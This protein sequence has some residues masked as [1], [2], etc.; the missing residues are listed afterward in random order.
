MKRQEESPGRSASRDPDRPRRF[1]Q[2]G[3]SVEEPESSKRDKETVLRKVLGITYEP[4]PSKKYPDRTNILV[5]YR[6][7]KPPRMCRIWLC[8]EYEEKA[9]WHAEHFFARR[10]LTCP[11]T[12]KKG[13]RKL[14]RRAQIPAQVELDLSGEFPQVVAEHFAWQDLRDRSDERGE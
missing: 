13:I 6:L 12:A 4:S 8:V 5:T 9:R 11:S 10:G 1:I 2:L 3:D 14:E 7:D